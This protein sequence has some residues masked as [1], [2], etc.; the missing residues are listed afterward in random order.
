SM[1]RTNIAPVPAGPFG[2]GMV[3]PMRPMTP[4]DTIRA[5]EITA[6][7]PAAHGA[8]VHFGDPTA[9]G[10]RDIGRP[11]WGDPQEIRPGEVPVF[12]ACGVTPQN[13]VQA[14]RP[15]LCIT[16]TPGSMLIT[17]RPA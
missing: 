11:D 15:S 2:G 5:V 8:P 7:H 6:G 13:A 17:D 9:I 16:H 14:A 12:W 10:I 3:V 4:A 1:H